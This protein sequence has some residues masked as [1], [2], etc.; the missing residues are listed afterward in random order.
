[1]PATNIGLL[2]LMLP[3]L[4]GLVY[5]GNGA[6]RRVLEKSNYRLERSAN[7]HGEDVVIY[8]IRR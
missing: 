8:R 4:V 3:S 1:M 6:S 5:V 2:Q 7:R